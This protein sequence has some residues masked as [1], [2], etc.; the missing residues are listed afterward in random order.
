MSTQLSERDREFLE[1]IAAR[2]RKPTRRQKAVAVL[3]FVQGVPLPEIAEHAGIEKD[4]LARLIRQFN[5]GGLAGLGLIP[6]PG[7]AKEG[8]S[9]SRDGTIESTPGVC[10]GSARVA[11]T[12][13]PVWALVEA[14]DLGVSEAQLLLDY[15]TLTASNLVDAWDYARSHEEEIAAE[16]HRNEVA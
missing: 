4:E 1:R 10:G 16:I 6:P 14:R 13:I 2:K 15:P 3:D 9:S 8:S 12:R 5:E 11:G 7:T